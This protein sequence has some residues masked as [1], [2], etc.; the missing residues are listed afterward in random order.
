MDVLC[1]MFGRILKL[2][3]KVKKVIFWAIDF[4]P[5][6]RF[7]KGWKNKIYHW[8]NISGYKNSDEMWDLSPRM[9]EAREKF[10]NIKVSDYRMHRVV[11][12]VCGLIR[13]KLI[14]SIK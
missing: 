11:L 10:L 14:P 5:E 9:L 12:T 2:S 7:K 13:L 8:I 6:N 4:V 1:S 3:G